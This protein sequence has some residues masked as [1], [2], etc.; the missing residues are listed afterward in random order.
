VDLDRLRGPLQPPLGDE[1]AGSRLLFL[2][3][4]VP[5]GIA[6]VAIEPASTGDIAVFAL[7][8]AGIARRARARLRRRPHRP[9]RPAHLA[10]VPDLGRA[11]RVS[12]AVPSRS[13]TRCG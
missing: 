13:A 4:S 12:I 11:V 8:L 7:A 5:S 2:A 1:N 3:A 9:A 10:R 6:A